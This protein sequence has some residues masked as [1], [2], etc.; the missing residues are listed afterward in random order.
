M[1]GSRSAVLSRV[2][3]VSQERL[4]ERVTV[5]TP[6]SVEREVGG[7]RKIEDRRRRERIERD[8]RERVSEERRRRERRERRESPRPHKSANQSFII[9]HIRERLVHHCIARVDLVSEERLAERAPVHVPRE[10]ISSHRKRL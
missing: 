9:A 2:D 1:R 3:L 7:E 6:R 8:R 5:H 4:A 10:T